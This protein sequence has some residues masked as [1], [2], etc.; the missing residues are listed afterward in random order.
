MDLKNYFENT[1]GTGV[2]ATADK[3]GR[4][5]AAIYARP[6]VMEDG[7]IAF[8]MRDKLTHHNITSNPHA[9]YLFI[10]KE[11][12]YQGKRFFLT[13]VREEKN[14]EL[15]YSLRRR[16]YPDDKDVDLFLVYFNIDEEL[17]LIGG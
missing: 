1:L 14:T 9:H 2:L 8:I 12:E 16:E 13:R 6:H 5:D 11:G 7:T 10:E 4:V 15:L 3:N 17:A